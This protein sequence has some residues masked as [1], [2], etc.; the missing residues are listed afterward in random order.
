MEDTRIRE[1]FEETV[2]G[3]PVRI[4]V[5]T[6]RLQF[7]KAF[8]FADAKK[9]IPYLD[10]L[11]VTDVYASPY[12]KAQPGSDHGYDIID[13]NTLNPDV[14]S[15]ADFEEMASEIRRRGMG[16][17]A[18]VVPNHM[19]IVGS[20]NAWWNDVLENGPCSPHA[21]FFDIDWKPIKEELEDKVILPILG[22][23]YGDVLE[24]Q[25]IKLS[26]EDGSFYINY[27]EHRLPIDPSTYDIVLTH[28]IERLKELLGDEN[29]IYGEFLSIVTAF[30]NLPS[31]MER[32]TER[33]SERLREKEIA[34]KRLRDLYEASEKFR[35]F[36]DENTRIFNGVPGKPESFDML[37][38]LLSAQ[39]YRLAFWRVATEE[40]NY[41]R[42]FDINDLGA[43][44]MEDE[45]V[46]N[47]AHFLL[48]DIIRKGFVT[49]V[50]VDHPDGLYNPTE[51]FRRLQ[52]GCFVALCLGKLDGDEAADKLKHL[53]RDALLNEPE[54]RLKRPFYVVGEKILMESERL[55]PEWPI[56]GTTGYGFMNSVNG[57]LIDSEKAKDIDRAYTRFTRQTAKFPELFYEK[58]KL[59][60]KTTMASEIN[61]LGHNLNR[62]SER[63]RHFRDFT[64]NN[65]I[66]AIVEV[67]AF[68]PVYRTYISDA[69]VSDSDRRYIEAAISRAKRRSREINPAV[70][71]FIRDILLL[72][73]PIKD[74]PALRREC[75]EFTMKFQ[76]LTGP[77]M[78]KGIE[79]TAFYSY[80]RLMSVNEVGGNPERLGI[81]VEAFHGQ[82]IERHKHW[83]FTLTATSTHDSKRSEDVRARISVL[84]EL[85]DEWR[86]G[87]I[88]WSRMNKKFKVKMEGQ[89]VPDRNEEYLLYQTLVGAWPIGE[90]EEEFDEFAERIK[91]YMIKAVRE[92]KTSSSWLNP[93][94][95]YEE[96]LIAFITRVLGFGPFVTDLK[97]FRD[98]AEHYGMLNSLSQALLKIMSPGV[99]D[100][101]QGTELWTLTLVDP[102][103]RRPV[104]YETQIRLLD[105]L[106]ARESSVERRDLAREL[107]A[108]SRDGRIKLYVTYRGLNFR[109]E[110]R[111]LLERGD[112]VPLHVSGK[113][114]EH[115]I[116]IG[117]F[118]AESSAITLVPRLTV[119]IAAVGQAPLGELWGDTSVHIPEGKTVPGYTNVFTGESIA[120]VMEQ[121]GASILRVAEVLSSF[122]VAILKKEQ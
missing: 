121:D 102:D 119:G 8:T 77:V 55:S 18:D 14:G 7:N 84:S 72:A 111:S 107:L 71:D 122:P 116:A 41:R 112:Y 29:A 53:Y 68:F 105:E 40:I 3:I 2:S 61:V 109:K 96:A 66:D 30:K 79:D 35:S 81:T 75:L 43:I 120:P 28:R 1:V 5:S 97:P 80:N 22:G 13:H 78:A 23:Q 99:P 6:Y 27:W 62:I 95:E 89:A 82:N 94:L 57:V 4:P 74:N 106:R 34:K 36:L 65:L 42:F 52:E 92:A 87:V 20:G 101:Y 15:Y 91:H 31:R 118:S 114:A 58:K 113:Y 60:M 49:G 93:D 83:P 115:V 21:P 104:D 73:Y 17:I 69:G 88:R 47:D 19:S 33:I 67:I 90:S 85:A 45:K 16:H 76:Q 64:L 10:A 46:F 70:Y 44:R 38:G 11:G 98:K 56:Y 117:H 59:I 48:F 110:N 54:G 103:N 25:E 12:F 86:K 26:F 39:V 100:F 50:R 108:T 37:D 32:D 63:D 51:Y 9:I 24:S